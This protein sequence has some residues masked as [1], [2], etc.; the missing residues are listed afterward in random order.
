MGSGRRQV[1][2][3]TQAV[4]ALDEAIGYISADSPAAAIRVLETAL[5]AASSLAVYS[6]RGRVVPELGS[7]RIRELAVFRYRLMYEVIPGEVWIVA[8]V[9]GSR[10][11]G[12]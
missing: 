9:H 7:P 1:V 8:F 11:F 4:V 10:N 5:E 6:E 12:E 2:W 3:S